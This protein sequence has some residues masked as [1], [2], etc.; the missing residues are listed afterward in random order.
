[1]TYAAAMVAAALLVFYGAALRSVLAARTRHW[2]GD[3]AFIGFVTMTWTHASF[4]VTAL[5]LHHAGGIVAPA[6]TVSAFL[7]VMVTIGLAV[8]VPASAEASP[9][10]TLHWT[11][12]DDGFFCAALTVPLDY[13]HPHGPS[14]SLALAKLPAGDP[15]HRIGSL[16]STQAAQESPESTSSRELA[17]SCLLRRYAPG[18]NS[19]GSILA[20]SGARR[21]FALT[22][23][24]NPSQRGRT[25]PIPTP[26]PR[27]AHRSG[28]TGSCNRPGRTSAG[29]S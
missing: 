20:G 8:A 6:I 18:S 26:R 19:S 12:C 16:T 9:A 15:A 23:G 13:D 22:P 28:T 7:A 17:P 11:A 24:S 27:P 14:I 5:A 4:A 1:M 2:T 3:A 10:S 25:S 21:C 29:R